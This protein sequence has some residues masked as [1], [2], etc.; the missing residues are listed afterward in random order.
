M[1]QFAYSY[2]PKQSTWKAELYLSLLKGH[3]KTLDSYMHSSMYSHCFLFLEWGESSGKTSG[4]N[5]TTTNTHYCLHT[6]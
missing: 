3:C 5:T 6:E 2:K 1:F 4:K